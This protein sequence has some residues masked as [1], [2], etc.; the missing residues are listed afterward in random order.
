VALLASLCALLS[1]AGAFAEDRFTVCSVTINSDDEI[2]TLKRSLPGSEFQFVELTDHAR[3]TAADGESS[4][5]GRACRSGVRCDVLVVSGHFGN[6]WAGNY[7]TT[8]AGSSDAT[9]SLEDLEQRRC[10]RSC[11]GILS[12]PLEVFL[13][14]CKT[15]S[16][17]ADGPMLSPS[18][19]AVL[20]RHRLSAASAQR[21]FDEARN[22]GDGTSS[23][24][25]MQFVFAG[26]P[27][28]YGFT[29]VAPS[30]KR[31][32]PLLESYLGSVG[33][34]AEHLRRLK[35]TTS[36]NRSA[37]PNEA[38]ARALQPTC[39]A[40]CGGL[41]PEEPAYAREQQACRLEDER[42]PVVRRLEEIEG[43]LDEPGFASY[44]P[45]IDAFFRTREPASFTGAAA[46]AL[47]R[48]RG[49]ARAQGVLAA[50]QRDL[51]SPILRLEILRVA[52][53]VGWITETEALPVRRQIVKQLLQPPIY[54]EGRDLI[55][56]M[57]EEVLRRVAI[58][59]EDVPPGV[60]RDEFGIQAL[61]CLR[62]ADERIRERL[63]RSRSDSREWIARLAGLAL[64]RMRPVEAEVQMAVV[65][66]IGPA[67]AAP[68]SRAVGA[69]RARGRSAPARSLR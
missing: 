32:A 64:E 65:D 56:G 23:R 13:L 51:Q 53:S 7:G 41:D 34:Y 62:P 8:F 36:G 16:S 35:R 15:L 49:H 52:R 30:G 21:I 27:R 39:F 17:T 63:A 66:R 55:C 47:E 9:L 44:L 25:R 43:L 12:D 61:G 57:G 18:D 46:A 1:S 6:T 3:M 59:A 58:R 42:S 68:R 14:G 48:I 31:V 45:A 38:L 19:V 37:P 40:Q 69:L 54:G 22:G 5:L 67:G 2:E 10:D 33:D 29:D 60:Y 50:L 24:Q 26:V 28:V 11:P 20:G 4:W